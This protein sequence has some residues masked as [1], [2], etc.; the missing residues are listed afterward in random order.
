MKRA[1]PVQGVFSRRAVEIARRAAIF[2]MNLQTPV[3]GPIRKY[4]RR[5]AG[6]D[7]GAA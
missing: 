6:V 4:Y 5:V 3:S 1:K 7:M 2:S